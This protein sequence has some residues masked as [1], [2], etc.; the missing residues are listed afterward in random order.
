MTESYVTACVEM[1][2]KERNLDALREKIRNK[3]REIAKENTSYAPDLRVLDSDTVQL[4]RNGKAL[5]SIYVS[6]FYRI[7][8]KYDI[9]VSREVANL[10]DELNRKEESF[11]VL[12]KILLSGYKS[13]LTSEFP[14]LKPVFARTDQYIKDQEASMLG[15]WTDLQSELIEF[16]A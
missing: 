16:F 4:Y 13:D 15:Q 6:D 5:G 12:K 2:K 14:A 1:L 7:D 11:E 9:E 3:V 10:F 8:K